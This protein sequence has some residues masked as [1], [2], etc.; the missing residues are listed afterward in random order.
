MESTKSNLIKKASSGFALMGGTAIISALLDL[1]ITGIVARRIVPDEKG[2]ITAIYVI[3]SFAEIFWMIG[4]GPAIVQKK[5]LTEKDIKTGQTITVLLGLLITLVVFFASPVLSPIVNISDPIYLRVLSLTFLING[6][7][8]ISESL[9]QKNMEFFKIS[10][11]RISSIF[12]QGVCT[13]VLAYLGFGVWALIAGFLAQYLSKSIIARI[14]RPVS[15]KLRIYK[16]SAKALLKFGAG[17][18]L[19][20][21]FNQLATQ[22]DNLVISNTLTKRDVGLYSSAYSMMMQPANLIGDVMDKVLFP[23]LSKLQTEKEKLRTAYASG[24]ILI[25]LCTFPIS[26]IFFPLAQ[27]VILVW[28]GEKWIG[29]ALPASILLLGLY[30]RTSYKISDSL[31]RAVGAV[32]K[33][34]FRQMIYAALVIVSAYLGSFWGLQGV[35]IGISLAIF[36]NYLLMFILSAK[37]ISLNIRDFL[38]GHLVIIAIS[39]IVFIINFFLEMYL[40]SLLISNILIILIAVVISLAVYITLIFLVGLRL[41]PDSFLEFMILLCGNILKGR[42]GGKAKK[43]FSSRLKN[44][45]IDENK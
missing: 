37:L 3:I 44:P 34:A 27:E 15:F 4:V 35:A 16:D 1:L 40:G 24:M 22:G 21:I 28:L 30:F 20:R 45:P 14:L 5:D 13:I 23:V 7:C 17:H 39:A 31:V 10:A 38:L 33:R 11:L 12:F 29:V 25:A 6:L 42:F 18:T 36:V 19:A 32:F 26:A 43:F 8:A 9:M 2:I 41:M